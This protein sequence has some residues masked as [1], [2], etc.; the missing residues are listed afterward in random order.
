MLRTTMIM[1]CL[2]LAAA[3]AG[4][5]RAEVLVREARRELRALEEARQKELSEVRILRAEIAFLE[6]PDRLA[7]VAERYT[8]LAPLTGDQLLTA[9]DFR[10]AFG[11]DLRAHA[12]D[13]AV[14]GA[15]AMADSNPS[16]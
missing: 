16:R 11:E 1:L 13:N 14:K 12:D 3:A 4:R 6:G 2:L 10:L 8:D 9:D 15:I 5:Y 7:G